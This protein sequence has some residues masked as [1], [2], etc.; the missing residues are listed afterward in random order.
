MPVRLKPERPTVPVPAGYSDTIPRTG[1]VP[2]P[3]RKGRLFCGGGGRGHNFSPR[4]TL[5][6]HY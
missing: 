3:V 5:A 6:H 1:G 4:D 2:A